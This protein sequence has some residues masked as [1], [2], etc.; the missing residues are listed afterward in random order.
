MTLTLR[1]LLDAW[2]TPQGGS[3]EPDA[4]MGRV[5]TDSRQLQADD[6]FV[7]LVGERF[8]GHHFLAQLPEHKVQA[9]V[10]SRS[11]TEPLPSG[12]LHWR[13]DDTLLAYQQL[14]L[15]HRRALAKPL[16]AVTGSAGKTTTRELIRAALAPLGAIQTSE[17]NNNNDVGVPLTVLGSTAADA[18]LVIEMGMRGPGEIERL[19]RCTEPD[20]AVITNIGTAHIGRLG[21]REAIAAAKCEITAGLHPKGTVV[22]PAG[23]PLLESALAAVWS[24]R[25]LR[26]R[27]ADDPEVE[28]D[29]VGDV[30]GDQ[31]LIGADRLPLQLEGR[32]N[33]RNLLLAVAV[34]DQLGVSRKALQAMQVMVPGGRNRRLQQGGL[35]LLDETYNASP[36]AVLAALELLA[37]QPGRRFAVLGTMLEL[38]ERSLELHQEVAARA[39]QLGLDGLV[40]VDGGEEGKAMAEVAAPLPHL[41]LVS[42]PEDA[43]APLAAWLNSGDVLLLKA[44]RGVALERLIPLLPSL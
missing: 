38:G 1:Q 10:V 41:Q 33:A 11:W 36:E 31:L 34:A 15:L 23:D 7:P 28:S 39:V 43:A 35:T 13:V 30:N 19:S 12:L 42:H 32:H 16:V 8:D 5:C 40:L 18:A 9:A 26:V 2:G 14:A 6:F 25:V 29:L 22:I 3:F 37:A 4:L 44:S 27:L 17:G 21:S 24:G 20:L